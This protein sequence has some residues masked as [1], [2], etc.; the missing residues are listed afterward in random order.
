MTQGRVWLT[1][2]SVTPRSLK[3]R[4]EAERQ[5]RENGKPCLPT[6]PC[7]WTPPVA[8]SPIPGPPRC[9]QHCASDTHPQP[10]GGEVSSRDTD[11]ADGAGK[12]GRALRTWRL[13][14]HQGTP[15]AWSHPW[16]VPGNHGYGYE[17]EHNGCHTAGD[18]GKGHRVQA[19]HT[20]QT[21]P[22]AAPEPAARSQT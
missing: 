13:G 7:P 9:L 16:R 11:E 10:A 19:Q 22:R 12:H 18:A 1:A 2:Q 21:P 15:Q 4:R 17:R 5:E 3:P 20:A 14:G 6:Q 8:D